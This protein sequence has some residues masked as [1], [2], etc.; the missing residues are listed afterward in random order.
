MIIAYIILGAV[1]FLE[2]LGISWLRKDVDDLE[3]E[4]YQLKEKHRDLEVKW[5]DCKRE[6]GK[7]TMDLKR[8][9]LDRKR[10]ER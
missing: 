1:V 5:R 7:K 2:S 8:A 10:E 4:V 9:E 6:L 3:A